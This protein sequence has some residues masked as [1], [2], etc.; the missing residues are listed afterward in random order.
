VSPA[1]PQRVWAIVESKEGGLFRS[2][3]GGDTWTRVNDNP[4]LRQRPWYYMHIFADP[5]DPDTVYVLNLGMWKS[6]DAG[7]SFTEIP[8]PHGD[9]HDLWIDP[10]NTKR[11]VEANDG[12]GCVSFDGGV[13]WSSIYN[14][15]TAQLYH[16][17]TDTQFP[18]RIYGAQ[19]DNTTITI[20]SYS[21]RG[22]ITEDDTWP[23]GGGES[24][25]IAVRPDNPDI[26]YAGSYATRMTRYDHGSRQ[27]V[28]ITVWPEDP[29]GY[30]AESMKYRFQWT[31]PIVLSPH[32]P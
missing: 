32:D 5:V 9:N 3:N 26:V 15:P 14:Q 6:V 23:V 8:T 12:G 31:F 7:S 30:G 17:I 10:A 19:Q 2:D 16:V 25:Y 4:D 27:Q 29:I 28:D 18:Y 13:T 21:D 11:M 22:A 24:G 20:P 1:R